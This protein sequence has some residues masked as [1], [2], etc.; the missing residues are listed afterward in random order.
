M[1]DRARNRSQ[2][3]DSLRLDQGLSDPQSTIENAESNMSEPHP[4]QPARLVHRS[5]PR[6]RLRSQTQ[7][8]YNGGVVFTNPAQGFHGGQR[9]HLNYGR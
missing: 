9:V 7:A 8:S 2:A 1:A 3:E 6:R 4:C 5:S